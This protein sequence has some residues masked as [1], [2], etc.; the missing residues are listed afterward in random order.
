M[1]LKITTNNLLQSFKYYL[2]YNV[3]PFLSEKEKIDGKPKN[4]GG[5][6]RITYLR[7]PDSE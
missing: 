4:P 6:G 2:F 7:I 3:S 5:K 1:N